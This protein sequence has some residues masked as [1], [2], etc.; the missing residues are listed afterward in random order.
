MSNF[1]SVVR[2]GPVQKKN[3]VDAYSRGRIIEKKYAYNTRNNGNWSY[4]KWDGTQLKASTSG[5]AHPPLYYSSTKSK[6][7]IGNPAQ[8]VAEI[9]KN[10]SINW[11][12]AAQV[13]LFGHCI[14]S[15]TIYKNVKILPAG[16]DFFWRAGHSSLLIDERQSPQQS[17]ISYD[18]SIEEYLYLLNESILRRTPREKENFAMGLSGGRDSRHI[19]LLLLRH[20]FKPDQIF[21][22]HHYLNFSGNEITVAKKL[23]HE[24]DLPLD[25]ILP[26][27]CRI[28]AETRKNIE[29]DFQTLSHSWGLNLSDKLSIYPCTYDGINAGVLFG[30]AGLTQLLSKKCLDKKP[31][32]KVIEDIVYQQCERVERIVQT[33][34]SPE[35][36]NALD[37][38]D[39]KNIFSAELKKYEDY[40]NIA[41][42]YLYFN[43]TIRDTSLFSFQLNKSNEVLCPFDDIDLVN[44]AL[45]L[46][47]CISRKVDFQ[48]DAMFKDFPE[49]NNIGFSGNNPHA[50]WIA[51]DI[52][53]EHRSFQK[54]RKSIYS[55]TFMQ[56]ADNRRLD[57]NE[58][59]YACYCGQ[60]AKLSGFN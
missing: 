28:R 38:F 20:G 24:L 9:S 53:R 12:A 55:K 16:A 25:V 18:H 29:L 37:F 60:I 11:S 3:G 17:D 50:P 13:L 40:Q 54:L 34:V 46:P 36:F 22:S 6:I 4:W 39:A 27:N 56:K 23:C 5:G 58:I 7:A 14:G 21:S 31:S 49:Q 15:E 32:L 44:F 10:T 2:W 57:L 26:D 45:A 47:W 8:R 42:A 59:Q 48:N 30:R 51:L 35:L 1:F 41:Q 52:N 33:I 19:L 43:H